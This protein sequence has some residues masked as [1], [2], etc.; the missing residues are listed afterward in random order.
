MQYRVLRLVAFAGLAAAATTLALPFFRVEVPGGILAGVGMLA[1]LLA[2][3]ALV[4]GRMKRLE[5]SRAARL[6]LGLVGSI[7]I[8]QTIFLAMASND[9]TSTGY[10]ALSLP[11]Q[12]WLS[13]SAILLFVFFLVCGPKESMPRKADS[14]ATEPYLLRR[15]TLT[16]L[17]G[18]SAALLIA[19]QL[20][21]ALALISSGSAEEML[22]A[23][24]VG[25]LIALALLGARLIAN[26][27]RS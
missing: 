27:V 17:I 16:F 21:I 1:V 2:I 6:T 15:R 12:R 9:R 19:R 5:R 22:V 25:I 3:F 18:L 7:W 13:L 14:S 8:V 24:A 26:G 4:R 20:M 11:H 23:G 10:H